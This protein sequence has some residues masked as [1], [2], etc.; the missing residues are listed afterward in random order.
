M[1]WLVVI[2]FSLISIGVSVTTCVLLWRMLE[3]SDRR[4]IL[5]ILAY[6]DELTAAQIMAE[7][8]DH[9]TP[10]IYGTLRAMAQEGLLSARVDYMRVE[11]HNGP[12]RP[13]TYYR[14]VM[15]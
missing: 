1:L 9:L 6:G 8:D 3:R 15:A 4:M 7:S 12:P 13:R 10:R 11:T 14:R 5:R 2:S